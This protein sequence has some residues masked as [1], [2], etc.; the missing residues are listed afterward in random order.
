[1]EIWSGKDITP[2][3]WQRIRSLFEAASEMDAAQRVAFL[4][5]N[6]PDQN[7]RAEVE[8]LL[9]NHD[10]AGDFLVEPAVGALNPTPAESHEPSL[11][12]GS[13]LAGRFKIVCFIASGG[14][15][16]VY[17]AEDLELHECLGIKTLR[18][19]VLQKASSV[20]RFKREVHLARKVTHPNVCRIFDLVRAKSNNGEEVVFVTMEFLRGETLAQ[21][22]KQHGRMSVEESLPLINQMASGLSAAHRAGIVHR[23]FKP[24]NV[25]LVDEPAGRRVVITDFGLAFR[26][27]NSSGETLSR[28]SWEPITRKGE[29]CGT[30]AYM[31]P[32]QIEGHPATAA[33]DIYAFGLLMFEMVTGVRPFEG[34]TPMSMAAKRL[35]ETPPTP[36]KFDPTLTSAWESVILRCLERDPAK[37]FAEAQDV[38]KALTEKVTGATRS[39]G[40]STRFGTVGRPAALQKPWFLFASAGLAVALSALILGMILYRSRTAQPP[41]RSEWVQL[42]DFPDSAT[43]PAVS[44]DGRVLAFI[45]GPSTFKSSG[46]ICVKVLPK[47]EPTQL[48]HDGAS[49]QDPRFSPDGSRVIYSTGEDTWEVPLLGGEPRLMMRNAT[50]LAWI[51]EGHVLFAELRKGTHMAVVTASE[52]RSEER[53]VYVPASETGMAHRSYL[54]PDGRWV[55]IAEMDGGWLPCRLVPFDGSSLGKPVGPPGAACTSAAWSPDGRWMYFSSN[56]AG[57]RFHIWRQ[58]FP[59][60]QPEQVTSGPTEEEGI[61]VAPDGRSFISSVGISQGTVWLHNSAGDQ[62]ISSEGSAEEPSFSA[63]GKKLFFL[64]RKSMTFA[65]PGGGELWEMDL[66]SRRAERPLPGFSANGYRV[67]ADAKKVAVVGENDRGQFRLWLAALDRSSPPRQIDSSPFLTNIFFDTS[68]DVLFAAQDGGFTFMYRVKQDGTERLKVLPFPILQLSAVSP[69]TKW[70]I[71]RVTVPSQERPHPAIMA[72]PTSGGPAVLV[73]EG[74]CLAGWSPAGNTFYVQAWRTDRSGRA[75]TVGVIPVEPD[76][77]I[78]PLPPAGIGSAADLA[79]MPGAKLIKLPAGTQ[80]F[81]L[82]PDGSTY[83]FVRTAVQRNLYRI[84]VP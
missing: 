32:E 44:P 18:S 8:K 58:R 3:I 46:D 80:D 26:S 64:V 83:A 2:E 11:I 29:F 56:A 66:D 13:L 27:P 68:G 20:E 6:C 74:F 37:R 22:M 16:E 84:A 81:A 41:T 54:S 10:K 52:S 63:D 65:N 25:V 69:D 61:T 50:G 55:L 42:T 12:P 76:H 53:N 79:A 45:H 21:Y 38:A 4:A 34:T 47:G 15:G 33:S 9:A 19:E 40:S 14:M 36:R 82:G 78:P 49:K 60:G 73:C 48:T 51:G 31:A 35:V 1:M 72:Y 43:S 39:A 7:I 70:V 71:A 24:G 62:Q 75:Q 17:E 28:V 67:G 30:P 23:D 77:V 57:G 59:R 5:Q